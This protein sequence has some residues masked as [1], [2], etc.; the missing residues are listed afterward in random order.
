[1]SRELDDLR[2]KE[3]A[4]LRLEKERGWNTDFPAEPPRAEL[5]LIEK[6]DERAD[7]GLIEP[8]YWTRASGYI[9]HPI[10][11][12]CDE[13]LTPFIHPVTDDRYWRCDG[14]VSR[15]RRLARTN[16]NQCGARM[17]QR[18]GK[19]GRFKDHPF[20]RCLRCDRASATDESPEPHA[21]DEPEELCRWCKAPL[22]EADGSPW[23]ELC[24]ECQRLEDEVYGADAFEEYYPDDVKEDWDW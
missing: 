8:F 10:C 11:P 5:E 3:Q 4:L 24:M 20:W 17:E 6:L 7:D 15:P 13:P 12:H 19:R 23:G 18:F 21:E 1:M 22:V 14:C 9:A 16:C 2:A